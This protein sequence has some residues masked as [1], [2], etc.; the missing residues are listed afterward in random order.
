VIFGEGACAPDPKTT[1][2]KGNNMT[3][4]ISL[5]PQ[6]SKKGALC[7]KVD[8]QFAISNANAVTMVFSS[9]EYHD[10]GNEGIYTVDNEIT[11]FDLPDDQAEILASVGMLDAERRAALLPVLRHMLAEQGVEDDNDA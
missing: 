7:F 2:T 5:H 6:T 11:V 4:Y 10:K 9:N 1:P 8:K 3:A